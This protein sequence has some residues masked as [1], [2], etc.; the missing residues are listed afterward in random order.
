MVERERSGEKIY[1]GNPYLTEAYIL[2]LRVAALM[3]VNVVT[4]FVYDPKEGLGQDMLESIKILRVCGVRVEAVPMPKE[5][6]NRR[7]TEGRDFVNFLNRYYL[8]LPSDADEKDADGKSLP[9]QRP[10]LLA[11]PELDVY[12]PFFEH[13]KHILSD[14]ADNDIDILVEK[15]QFLHGIVGEVISNLDEGYKD[16][17]WTA[18]K[19]AV[20][21][22]EEEAERNVQKALTSTMESLGVNVST[23]D[24]NPEHF[25]EDLQ[26]AD[27][28]IAVTKHGSLKDSLSQPG[29][30]KNGTMVIEVQ[31]PDE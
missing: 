30:V 16:R 6:W 1:G 29:M 19:I 22:A 10:I 13:M 3:G 7:F 12:W 21:G 28:I 26:Q 23:L 18:K 25:S 2:S 8:M 24:K 9:P 20:V 27:I 15:G 17:A 11:P 14:R 31:L 4:R 5:E